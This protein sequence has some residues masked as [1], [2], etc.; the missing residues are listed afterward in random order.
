AARGELLAFERFASTV[1]IE[2]PDGVLLASD[3][4]ILD[5]REAMREVGALGSFVA[6]GTLFVIRSG[7]APT[8]LRPAEN[9]RWGPVS[10]AGASTLPNDAGAWLRVLA[11]RLGAAV[12]AIAAARLAPRDSLP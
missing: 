9:D 5:R 6:V 7:F 4:L 10:I 1:G 12:E 8:S 11:D 2:R 3:A